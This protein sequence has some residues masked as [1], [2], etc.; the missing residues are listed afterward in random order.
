MVFTADQ[1]KPQLAVIDTSTN[2]ATNWV[3]LPASG[4]GTAATKDG[5]WLLVALPSINKVGVVDLST[6]KLTR[7]IDVCRSPQEILVRPDGKVA[8]VSCSGSHQVAAIDLPQWK[9]EPFIEA[10]NGADGLAWAGK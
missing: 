7:T 9:V 8:Y 5:H 2:K 10:G 1:T 3:A 4:Y 6:L